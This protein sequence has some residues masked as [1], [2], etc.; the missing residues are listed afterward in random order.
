MTWISDGLI[1]ILRSQNRFF[2][3]NLVIFWIKHFVHV[4]IFYWMW[5]NILKKLTKYFLSVAAIVLLDVEG[6]QF[7]HLQTLLNHIFFI[8][9]HFHVI[10]GLYNFKIPFLQKKVFFSS[11]FWPFRYA[12][13]GLILQPG[14]IIT[15]LKLSDESV[16]NLDMVIGV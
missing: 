9:F 16:G 10:A 2:G 3:P 13:H 15:W 12:P 1:L 14:R 5:G 4:S 7:G 8:Q 11:F 6:W